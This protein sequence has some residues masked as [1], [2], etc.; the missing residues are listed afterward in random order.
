MQ[1]IVNTVQPC[2]DTASMLNFAS[3]EGELSTEAW[4]LV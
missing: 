2:K 1:H 4:I 3:R